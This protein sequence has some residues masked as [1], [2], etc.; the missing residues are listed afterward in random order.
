MSAFPVRARVFASTI[1]NVCSR[2]LNRKLLVFLL[3]FLYNHVTST[4]GKHTLVKTYI[5]TT[6]IGRL[7]KQLPS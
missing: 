6:K 1:N 4:H 7:L 5:Y 3:H 2:F